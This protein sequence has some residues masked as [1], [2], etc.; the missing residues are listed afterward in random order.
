MRAVRH[1][2]VPLSTPREAMK[3]FSPLLF[4]SCLMLSPCVPASASIDDL[5]FGDSP[6]VMVFLFALGEAD[7]MTDTPGT[8]TRVNN[9]ITFCKGKIR[10]DLVGRLEHIVTLLKAKK[11]AQAK[12]AVQEFHDEIYGE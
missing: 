2:S 9:A 1:T 10:E 5:A 7:R 11:Y 8:I 4:A 3:R 6:A 12:K